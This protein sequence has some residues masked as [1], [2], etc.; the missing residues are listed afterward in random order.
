MV[1]TGSSFVIGNILV[2]T[3]MLCRERERIGFKRLMMDNSSV[4]KVLL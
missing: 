2:R 3:D 4:F 1:R